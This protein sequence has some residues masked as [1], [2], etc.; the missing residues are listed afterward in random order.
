MIYKNMNR[1]EIKPKELEGFGKPRYILRITPR[2]KNN[3]DINHIR[4]ESNKLFRKR[5]NYNALED[6]LKLDYDAIM[7]KV[8]EYC[9]EFIV[10]DQGYLIEGES[11]ELDKQGFA[12]F[13]PNDNPLFLLGKNIRK[14][15][16]LKKEDKKTF[17]I[18]GVRNLPPFKVIPVELVKKRGMFQKRNIYKFVEKT[19]FN[20]FD[21]TLIKYSGVESS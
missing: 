5:K 9:G 16:N 19:S 3:R 10:T 8:K 17:Y 11:Y 21:E 20:E 15:S 4:E 7:E 14:I 13:L 12:Y 2:Y 1:E 6:M 18:E